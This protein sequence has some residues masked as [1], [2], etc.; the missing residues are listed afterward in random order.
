M[1]LFWWLGVFFMCVWGVYFFVEGVVGGVFL[2]FFCG[3]WEVVFGWEDGV[4]S[5]L[6][7]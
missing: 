2:L 5:L 7:I 4:G 3:E 6:L 1:C